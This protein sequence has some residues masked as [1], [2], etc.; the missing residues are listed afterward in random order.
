MK[1]RSGILFLLLLSLSVSAMATVRRVS[2]HGAADYVTI[3][4]A[5]SASVAGDTIL[6]GDGSYDESVTIARPLTILGAGFDRTFTR[7][8]TFASGSSRSVLEGFDILNTESNNAVLVQSGVDSVQIR[9]CRIKNTACQPMLSH[10]A[11]AGERL[12]LED[13]VFMAA[14]GSYYSAHILSLANDSVF[15]CNCVFAHSNPFSSYDDS[16]L[17]GTPRTLVVSNCVFLACQQVFLLSTSSLLA[18]TNCILYDWGASPEW[19]TYSAGGLFA[20]NAT[21]FTTALP[22]GV[23]WLTLT[24]NPFASYD[25]ALN[26]QPGV[27]NLHLAS[28]SPCLDAGD[29]AILDRDSTRCDMGVYGGPAPLL[30]TGAPSYPITISITFDVPIIEVG[31][32]LRF[33]SIGR[34]GPRY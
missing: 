7:R 13:C 15:V 24:S 12:I 34:I 1:S 33:H 25:P 19:G 22:T 17:Q 5:Y 29:P 10:S 16:A 14:C 4:A 26:Y 18:F 32:S 8:F 20:Y 31:D 30:D 21:S 27:S 28:G 3:A 23:A 2:T 9:R 6:V 11:S